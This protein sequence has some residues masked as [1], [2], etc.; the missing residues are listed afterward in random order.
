MRQ[1]QNR[2]AFQPEIQGLRA[3][4]VLLVIYYHSG[5]PGLPGGY[6]GVD[7]FFVISGYLITGLLL[8]EV[9]KHGSISLPR[10]YARRFRRLLPAAALVLLVTTAVAWLVYSPLAIKQYSS[11]AFA[12]AIYVSNLW[13]ASL[14]TDYLAEN[15][16]ANPL[17]HTWSLGV[18]EQFYIVWPLLIL[19]LARSVSGNSLHRRMQITFFVIFA[20]SLLGS[21][22]LTRIN[23]PWAFFGSPTRAWE[24]AAGAMVTLWFYNNRQLNKHIA[25][26]VGWSG[27]GCILVSAV[28]YTR[29]TLFPGLAAI[30][31]VLGTTLIIAS[32][33]TAQKQ[34]LRKTLSM[35]AM[36]QIGNMSY[37][38][39]LWH[40][41]VFVYWHSGSNKITT[42]DTFL[43]IALVFLLSW[44]TLRLLEDPIRFNRRLSEKTANSLI[45]GLGLTI[46]CALMAL[47]VR[48]I[49]A[50]NLEQPVQKRILAA[51]YDQPIIYDNG[52]HLN[53]AS[54]EPMICYFGDPVGEKLVVLFGDSHA[55]QWFPALESIALKRNWRL[56]PMTKSGCPS[57]T[58]EPFNRKVGRAYTECT[59]WRNNVV[60]LIRTHK[61]HLTILSNSNRYLN[62]PGLDEGR[63]W[64][65]GL[66]LTLEQISDVS[67]NVVI[68]GDTPSLTRDAPDC[69][70]H[71]F[72]RGID[73]YEHCSFSVRNRN[74]DPIF[75]AETASA[76][77]Y[78]N[79]E[80][81]D[82]TEAICNKPRC[83]VY[84]N[85]I[86]KYSDSH[87]LT[88][89]FSQTLSKEL[90]SRLR[91]IE[92]RD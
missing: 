22:A 46:T 81:V 57:V 9:D 23:Q 78:Q 73:P 72:W 55:A 83:A 69:L 56:L 13:F 88:G 76:K 58:H 48:A 50:A 66:N 25:T 91:E 29:S 89:H 67:N 64:Q 2:K 39:Y 33:H 53:F 54:T 42:V 18:E 47:G 27:L 35:S 45:M 85:G 12:T 68:L 10:F 86:V 51:K 44:L 59:E 77:K 36:Q 49:S 90:D 74:Q 87:H 40:W 82:M 31:P 20:A 75:S 26:I 6:I 7:V 32:I 5:L 41:P 14:T 43:S 61:P 34:N 79:A 62:D 92:S 80:I 70:S 65:S 24:F 37:S 19:L 3:L 8:N 84:E 17:L 11:S 71:S 21:I 16:D 28:F 1:L 30:L 60:A 38:L 15:T 4:A 63:E 52:C